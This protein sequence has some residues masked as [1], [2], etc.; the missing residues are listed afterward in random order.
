MRFIEFI[1]KWFKRK[2]F[3]LNHN[4]MYYADSI[5]DLKQ[6]IPKVDV[7]IK[8]FDEDSL[9]QIRLFRSHKL[10]NIL[11]KFIDKGYT[12]LYA[13]IDDEIAAYG[14][15]SVNKQNHSINPNKIFIQP[16]ESGYIFHCYTSEKFRGK[17][18]YSYIIYKLSEYAFRNN[19]SKVY[20]DTE[21]SNI[22]AAKGVKKINFKF[23]GNLIT[24][25]FFSK[26][27][28]TNSR[29]FYNKQL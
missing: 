29:R 27:V 15:I 10:Y 9:K 6:I 17:N 8:Q 16:P 25:L 14:W 1:I 4:N 26:I 2:G 5:G 7:Q 19:V 23:C 12:G 22:A 18:L 13:E 11:Q 28:F 24:C 21:A 3:G 20:I